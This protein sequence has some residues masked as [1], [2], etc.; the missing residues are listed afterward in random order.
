MT[1]KAELFPLAYRSRRLVD[2]DTCRSAPNIATGRRGS[3]ALGDE[4]LLPGSET[5]LTAFRR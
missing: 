1:V 2:S 4:C 5:S 3:S